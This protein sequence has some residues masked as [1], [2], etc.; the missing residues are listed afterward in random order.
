MI[1]T[2]GVWFAE[3]NYSLQTLPSESLQLQG[4]QSCQLQFSFYFVTRQAELT[5]TVKVV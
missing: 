3:C 5:R 2:R 4:R 1:Y